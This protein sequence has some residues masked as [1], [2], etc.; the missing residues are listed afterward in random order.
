MDI[1][2]DYTWRPLSPADIP[3]MA[4]LAAACLEADGGLPFM[5]TEAMIRERGWRQRPDASIA[6][7]D[8]DRL[9]AC[10]T[11]HRRQPPGEERAVIMGQVHPGY[12][13]RRA[14]LPAPRLH[15]HRPSRHLR[16]R[17]RERRCGVME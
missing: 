1:P 9:V 4:A 6:A 13:R 2:P 17:K 14:P 16:S 10:A 5:A 12:R 7:F 11:V 15:R 3:A 8:G